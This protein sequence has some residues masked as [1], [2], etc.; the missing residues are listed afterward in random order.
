MTGLALAGLDSGLALRGL[1]LK[2][3]DL[4]GIALTGLDVKWPDLRGLG[5]T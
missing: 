5:G 4:E 2:V 1:E 3:L